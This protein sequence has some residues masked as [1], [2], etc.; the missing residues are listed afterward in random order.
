MAEIVHNTWAVVTATD[1]NVYPSGTELRIRQLRQPHPHP[2]RYRLRS[3]R[4][5]WRQPEAL[6]ASDDDVRLE[7]TDGFVGETWAVVA[8]TYSGVHPAT[9]REVT[10]R[11]ASVRELTDGLISEERDDD[12][13]PEMLAQ[14]EA[15]SATPAPWSLPWQLSGGQEQRQAALLA[16]T[17]PAVT[18]ASG[19][20]L[21]IDALRAEIS[22]QGG[23]ITFARFMDLALYHPEWG[24]YHAA[25]RRPG[26]PGDFLTAPEAHPFFGITLARQIA[27]CWERLGQPDRF[28]VREYGPGIGGLAWD[29]LGGL[30]QEHP[31]CVAAL[32]YELVERNPQRVAEA[33]AAF[34]D[35]GLGD[36]VRAVDPDAIAALPPMTGVI[37]ANE[38]ADAFPVHRLIWQGGELREGWVAWDGEGFAEE[39]AERSPQA[40]DADPAGMLAKHSI[41]LQEGA[42]VEISPAA[43]T[44]FTA[45]A[46]RLERGYAIIIDYGYP[47]AQLYQGH[48]LEGTVRAYRA[49]T[50]TDDPFAHV[51][52]Q[53]LTAHVDFTA[54]R[55]AGA[56]A[57]LTFAG[58]TNQAAFLTSL[59]M[60]NLMVGLGQDPE[61]TMEEYLAAQAAVLR[62]ID[63][64]SLGR[65][66]VLLMARTAPVEPPLR[67]LSF[68]PL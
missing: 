23:R 36:T 34:R 49:H 52:E 53:D 40:I 37:L 12:D 64:G 67:G 38:V 46:S 7:V 31:A 13:L 27:D 25:Q 28:V 26:R 63:P 66:G 54:L 8:W 59:D 68:P 6:F 35:E 62:L 32:S 55:D 2:G 17:L 42:R 5:R 45:A 15:T 16:A 19:N 33:L 60:G 1:R 24:Y 29:I 44:W 39:I 3:P 48:R 51:G 50:V 4:R 11:R 18:I 58:Q 47:A 57:G 21:L 10:F 61:T 41:T 14:I 30:Q 22:A 9:G 43:A 65:F 56:A 20:S